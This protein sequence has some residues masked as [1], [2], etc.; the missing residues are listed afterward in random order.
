MYEL[1]EGEVA[2]NGQKRYK[3]REKNDDYDPNIGDDPFGEEEKSTTNYSSNTSQILTGAK[4]Q[5]EEQGN[6]FNLLK[7]KIFQEH[8]I[9]SNL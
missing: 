7:I 1:F 3:R 8:I 4:T 5:S 2:K 9:L 6:Q